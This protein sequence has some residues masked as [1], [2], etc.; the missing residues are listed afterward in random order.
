MAH[1][2][3]KGL[4]L[5]PNL[6]PIQVVI[7]PIIPKKDDKQLVMKKVEEINKLLEKFSVNSFIS[8]L[9]ILEIGRA[10]V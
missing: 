9:E 1:G 3:D 10:H 4:K 5:P 7:V 2:D 6:A 8:I